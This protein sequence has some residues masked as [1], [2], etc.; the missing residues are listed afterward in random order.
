[1]PTSARMSKSGIVG[2]GKVRGNSHRVRRN[3]HLA[4]RTAVR[5][6]SMKHSTLL[7]YGV[8]TLESATE[9]HHSILTADSSGGPRPAPQ[10]R[11]AIATDATFEGYMP[12]TYKFSLLV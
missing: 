11:Q 6:F 2:N 12:A 3:M 5:S 4:D 8:A 1:M 10:V 7:R 9:T